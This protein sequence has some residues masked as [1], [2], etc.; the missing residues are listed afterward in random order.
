MESTFGKGDEERFNVS[1]APEVAY[2]RQ[3]GLESCTRQAPCAE[4]DTEAVIL[5]TSRAGFAKAIAELGDSGVGAQ[6]VDIMRDTGAA[7]STI[8][9]HG[10]AP[11][12]V[13]MRVLLSLFHREPS[14]CSPTRY[15]LGGGRVGCSSTTV[16][17]GVTSL[18]RNQLQFEPFSALL[19]GSDARSRVDL[20]RFTRL[21]RSSLSPFH[22]G[23]YSGVMAD[24]PQS[25]RDGKRSN[26]NSNSNSSSGASSPAVHA[27]SNNLTS[28][29]CYN[30]RTSSS[31]RGVWYTSAH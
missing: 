15:V 18:V 23:Y 24:S 8:P 17:L 2:R 5:Y 9:S 13:H 20:L 25:P 16:I 12:A 11:G 10:S 7:N 14:W 28:P 26:S 22:L 31:N 3:G 19:L 27:P 30:K 1:L 29:P 6:S 21:S 4:I